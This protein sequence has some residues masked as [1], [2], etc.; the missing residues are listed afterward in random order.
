MVIQIM[1]IVLIF[2]YIYLNEE[3]LMPLQYGLSSR[4]LILFMNESSPQLYSQSNNAIFT[5][6]MTRWK[7]SKNWKN[8]PHSFNTSIIA[9]SR[10]MLL[11]YRGCKGWCRSVSAFPMLHTSAVYSHT[12]SPEMRTCDC[13]ARVLYMTDRSN[14]KWHR[15]ILCGDKVAPVVD[16]GEL[17]RGEDGI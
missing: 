15:K 3:M 8:I 14:C 11:M 13:D 17:G 7:I 16:I 1:H 6:V 2:D 10:S 4:L 9:I 12:N 5:R